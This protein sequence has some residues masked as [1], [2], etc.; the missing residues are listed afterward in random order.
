MLKYLTFEISGLQLV[1]NIFFFCSMRYMSC[2]YFLDNFFI[3]S[4]AYVFFSNVIGALS[5][6]WYISWGDSFSHSAVHGNNQF[7]ISSLSVMKSFLFFCLFLFLF[8]K[9]YQCK[10]YRYKRESYL[11][12]SLRLNL[13]TFLG[14][15]NPSPVKSWKLT[16]R[17][18]S[19][20]FRFC[21][22]CSHCVSAKNVYNRFCG[23]TSRD[24][25][26]HEMRTYL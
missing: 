12:H 20:C 25:F 5:Q 23:M 8:C 13:K 24:L 3:S 26:K 22:V 4:F 16:S 9:L 21:F 14:L 2:F 15:T 7:L 10:I 1:L 11:N 6:L 17:S 18:I 19:S